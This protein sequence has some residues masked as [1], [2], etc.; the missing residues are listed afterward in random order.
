MSG[1]A[2]R[3]SGF[4]LGFLTETNVAEL[5]GRTVRRR[6]QRSEIAE[7]YR[8]IRDH[9]DVYNGKPQRTGPSVGLLLGERM[10]LG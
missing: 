6:A 1:T 10:P 8:L 9:R 4:F 5:E 7:A 3:R 2:K